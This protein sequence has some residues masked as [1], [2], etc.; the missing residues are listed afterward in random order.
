MPL[1]CHKVRV[2]RVY[3]GQVVSLN[4]VH[5]VHDDLDLVTRRFYFP[6]SLL[7]LY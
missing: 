3:E 4:M 2:N 7:V 5:M 6:S 1:P